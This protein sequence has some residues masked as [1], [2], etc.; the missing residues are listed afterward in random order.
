M[1]ILWNSLPTGADYCV[2][3]TGSTVWAIL[4]TIVFAIAGI[5]FWEKLGV[6]HR[7]NS[8]KSL[9]QP[10]KEFRRATHVWIRFRD[11]VTIH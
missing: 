2:I 9:Y 3:F 10:F 6:L 1:R 7:P 11:T 5:A 8:R 4:G